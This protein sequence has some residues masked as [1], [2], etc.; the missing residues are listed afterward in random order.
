M[1][2]RFPSTGAD[3]FVPARLTV[4][5]N[6]RGMKQT[7]LAKQIRRAPATISKWEND[8]Y[9][10]APDSSAIVDLSDI[11]NVEKS[12]FYKA[13]P[14]QE[15]V[16]FFRSLKTE[17]YLVRDKISARLQFVY[18]IF[19]ELDKRVEFPDVDVPDLMRGRDYKTLRAEDIDVI[20]NELRDYWMLGD[21][22]IE[23]LMTVI[24][25]AGIVVAEDNVDSAKLDGV[26]QWINQRPFML[27]A[28]DKDGGVR[29]RFD[30]A[31]EL[32][33][34]IMHQAVSQDDITNHLNLIEDQAMIFAG[35]FLLPAASFSSDVTDATLDVLADIK[36]KW[37]VSIGA[38]IKR[39]GTLNLITDDHQRNLWKY[40][41]YRKWR[42]NEPYDDRIEVERPINVK[43]AIE[44]VASDG[45]A[46][47]A[48]LMEDVGL[49]AEVVS[50]LS[51]VRRATL[52]AAPAPKPRLKLVTR[53]GR[54]LETGKAAN[55]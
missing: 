28:K 38:M 47:I 23:D 49:S 1:E 4:A 25:N 32:G 50:D 22:P 24:E 42:G 2:Q 51:G 27:L 40:Y 43:D 13:M 7:E 6:A 18:D 54:P 30:A 20:A 14:R 5:R 53:N 26:S 21:D 52:T 9:D 17:L 44:M 15:G 12:W 48:S 19:Y 10:H 34:I 37:K 33:H 3:G 29:R 55:D 31:H 8:T 41:S 16:A 46:E 36:P 35:A 45:T 11:L 39:L